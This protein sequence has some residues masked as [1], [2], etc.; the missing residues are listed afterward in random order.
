MKLSLAKYYLMPQ[1]PLYRGLYY[2]N[3]NKIFI[4]SGIFLL[5]MVF[6]IGNYLYLN[7]QIAQQQKQLTEFKQIN[8]HKQQ[9]L[10]LLQQRYQLAQDKSELLT[11]IN[12]Q[13][14]KILDKNSVEIDSIQWNM[15][16]R[17]IYLLISQSTQKVLNVIADL[18]QLTMVKF[19]EIHLTKKTKQKH[20]Q[21][22][23]TLLFQAD[24]GE[25]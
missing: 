7:Q 9:Q 12:Q 18:N 22:N 20:I 23:A 15:E 16:E 19:Q 17:K 11:Q 3:Q 1:H 2:L 25:P 14:Q 21:L 24:T 13:I 10:K 8:E 4:L 6:P 5:I